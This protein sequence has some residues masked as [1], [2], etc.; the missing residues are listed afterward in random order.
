MKRLTTAT[1]LLFAASVLMPGVASA[2][3]GSQSG[4]WDDCNLNPVIR[5]AGPNAIVSV[6]ITEN[7]QGTMEGTYVGTERDV[8]TAAGSVLFHGSGVFT[9]TIN[10]RTGTA[11]YRYTGSLRPG[12]E[13]FTA[14]WVMIGTTG[15]LA[16]STGHGTF[17]GTQIPNVNLSC[18][19]GEYGGT[20]QGAFRFAR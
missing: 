3:Q 2:G 7:F 13:R 12:E 8:V 14:R 15:E 16:S 4:T 20:Y 19:G 11:V 18:D 6:D 1:A 9:G 5:M 17:E 10:D